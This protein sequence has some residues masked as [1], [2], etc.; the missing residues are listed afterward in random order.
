MKKVVFMSDNSD[1]DEL[2]PGSLED[3]KGLSLQDGQVTFGRFAI[4]ITLRI[5]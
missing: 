4:K 5:I 2:F 1:R 3:L